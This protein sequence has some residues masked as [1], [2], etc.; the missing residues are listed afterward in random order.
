[1][2]IERR[3][4]RFRAGHRLS[5]SPRRPPEAA[6]RVEHADTWKSRCKVR[7]LHQIQEILVPAGEIVGLGRDGQVDLRLVLRIARIREDAGHLADASADSFEFLDERFGNFVGQLRELFTD[8][9]A[10]QQSS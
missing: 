10:S 7:V 8:V 1:V 5:P 9:G 3:A 6:R 2:V 4:F